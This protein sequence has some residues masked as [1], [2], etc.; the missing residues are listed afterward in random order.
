LTTWFPLPENYGDMTPADQRTARLA[1]LMAQSTPEKLVRA[2]EFFRNIYLKPIGKGFYRTGFVPSPPFHF[3]MIEDLGRY[4]RNAEAAPRGSAKSTVI[5]CEVI[6]LL[7]L[8]RPYFSIVLGMATDSLIEARFDTVMD[9][10]TTNPLIIE[11]FGN[12]KPNRGDAIWNHHH[13]HLNNG[14]TLQGFSVMGR[15][16]GA[17]AHLFILDDPES[18]PDSESQESQQLVLEKF[19]RILFR[20]IIPML[21]HGSAIFWIGTLINRRSFLYH[22]TCSDD[23]RF[24]FWNRRVFS[25]IDYNQIDPTHVS[26]LWPDKM[27]RE[28][29]EARRAEIGDS[30]FAAEYMN[31][32]TSETARLF[33]VDPRLNEYTVLDYNYDEPPTKNPFASSAEVIWYLKDGANFKEC[34]KLFKDW[35]AP[36]YRIATFDFASGLGQ[37]A[38]YSCLAIMGFDTFNILWLLDMWLGRARDAQLLSTIYQMTEKWKVRIIGVESSSIQIQFAEAVDEF[39][40]TRSASSLGGWRPRVMPVKYPPNMSKGSRIAGLEWRFVAGKIKY[41]AHLAGRWPFSQ[42]YM[43][44]HDF[45]KDLALLPK[46]D[47]VDTVA[48]SQYVVHTKGTKSALGEKKKGTL[49]D[50]IMLGEQVTGLPFLS[51]ADLHS[52][53][54][55]E[56]AALEDKAYRT[57]KV[58][59]TRFDIRR[60]QVIG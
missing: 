16:R 22:A 41:P 54:P 19:E 42:L 31:D 18:D 34:K 32:P 48:M 44:T 3:T 36:M 10:L 37:H 26:I 14:S 5:G 8:T 12:Q 27:S 57:S 47:A 52:L 51:S 6:L 28:F 43:Q 38:D 20:Q 24:T 4:A 53:T 21:E 35:I 60:P 1:I 58:N 50:R 33:T 25:A 56:M 49:V 23:P 17:R 39:V 29:L 30:A 13:I 9:Q 55:E 46:D 15:K 59:R 40:G 45:T 7:L 11:D 2:W